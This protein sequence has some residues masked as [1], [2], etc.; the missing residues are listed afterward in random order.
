MR[1]TAMMHL[2][3]QTLAYV[4]IFIVYLAN[5]LVKFSLPYDFL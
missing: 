4:S 1:A 5:G 3:F 2:H